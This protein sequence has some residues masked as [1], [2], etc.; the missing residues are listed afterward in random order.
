MQVFYGSSVFP[1]RGMIGR[2]SA[3]Q[4]SPGHE[5]DRI[6]RA[7]LLLEEVRTT[8]RSH[9]SK[10]TRRRLADAI[11]RFHEAYGMDV[12]CRRPFAE[13]ANGVHA[14]FDFSANANRR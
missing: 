9:P 2:H 8:Y 6:E 1:L 10:A 7:W 12:A 14:L 5:R 4:G 3:E 13:P 11:D